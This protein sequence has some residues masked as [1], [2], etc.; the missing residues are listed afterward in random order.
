MKIGD[1]VITD[2]WLSDAGKIG[3]VI[4]IQSHMH[5]TLQS[6]RDTRRMTSG[7]YVLFNETGIRLINALNLRVISD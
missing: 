5:M 7:I 4:K 1:L 3:M 6:H 2:P